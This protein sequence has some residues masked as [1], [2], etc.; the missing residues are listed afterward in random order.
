M[1]LAKLEQNCRK[2]GLGNAPPRKPCP[3]NINDE[4]MLVS[5]RSLLWRPDISRIYNRE[6]IRILNTILT[7][8]GHV[9]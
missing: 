7:W 5:L 2:V 8:I 1:T 9:F 6:R 3:S 4:A